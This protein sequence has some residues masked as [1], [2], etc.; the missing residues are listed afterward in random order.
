L[1]LWDPGAYQKRKSGYFGSNGQFFKVYGIFYG[2]R[3]NF[4]GGEI[5]ESRYFTAY[6]VPKSIVSDNAMDF[7]QGYFM[8]F[9]FDGD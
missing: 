7:R 1:P 2:M 9:A 6:G 5:E 3:H 8:S 4:H